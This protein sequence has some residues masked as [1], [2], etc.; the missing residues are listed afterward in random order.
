[1]NKIREAKLLCTR[2]GCLKNR[3]EPVKIENK[4]HPHI[5]IFTFF[6]LHNLHVKIKVINSKLIEKC[7]KSA[8]GVSLDEQNQLGAEDERTHKRSCNLFLSNKVAFS[9][10]CTL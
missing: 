2:H 8:V 4:L 10:V 7:F 9:L 5:F 1:M 6:V 3:P